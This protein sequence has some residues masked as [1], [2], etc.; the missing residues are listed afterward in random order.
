ML[1][2]RP[3]GRSFDEF[4]FTKECRV[5][6]DSLVNFVK[7]IPPSLSLKSG[8]IMRERNKLMFDINEVN[9][10]CSSIEVFRISSL[11]MKTSIIHINKVITKLLEN[12]GFTFDF[13]IEFEDIIENEEI[14]EEKKVFGSA[15]QSISSQL[16]EIANLFH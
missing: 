5:I 10:Y 8:E 4:E 9:L 15:K 11:N 2:D 6:M 14:I 16:N 13:K 12:L 3:P 1:K 7:H